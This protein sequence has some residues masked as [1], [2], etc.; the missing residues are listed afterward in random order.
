[1]RFEANLMLKQVHVLYSGNVQ[2]VGFRFTCISIA[3]QLKIVGWIRNLPGG[4]VELVAEADE[5]IL[6][7]MLSR[8][9]G[10]FSQYIDNA[11]IQWFDP[12]GSF[13]DFTAKF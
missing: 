4:G 6:K 1:M 8:V 12:S 7:D 11:D 10:E 5:E 2:G 13:K 3:H 9:N